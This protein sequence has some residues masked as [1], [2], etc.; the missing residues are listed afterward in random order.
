MEKLKHTFLTLVILS[1]LGSVV[2]SS[3][4]MLRGD[5]RRNCNHPEHGKYMQERRVKKQGL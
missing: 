3:C 1:L 5:P 2:L 4:A